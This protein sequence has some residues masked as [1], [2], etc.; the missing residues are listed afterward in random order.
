MVLTGHSHVIST[1]FL[2]RHADCV[3]VN[4]KNMLGIL[5]K[6]SYLGFWACHTKEKECIDDSRSESAQAAITL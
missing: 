1:R 4:T 3:C 5:Q 6:L 2:I